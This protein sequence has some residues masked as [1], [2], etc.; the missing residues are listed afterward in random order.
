MALADVYICWNHQPCMTNVIL[1]NSR[2]C[3]V[4]HVAP[5]R[6]IVDPP[7]IH[8]F[9]ISHIIRYSWMYLTGNNTVIPLNLHHSVI[10]AVSRS[11]TLLHFSRVLLPIPL[12]P[13]CHISFSPPCPH[14]FIFSIS[15]GLSMS[16][17]VFHR[18]MLLCFLFLPILPLG[19]PS[20]PL[21]PPSHCRALSYFISI[22]FSF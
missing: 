11:I 14:L 12:S 21:A 16:L 7:A 22:S 1:Q 2:V 8:L 18:A 15:L 17:F 9:L 6:H 19:P 20:F 3:R 13:L 5:H 10:S 4:S